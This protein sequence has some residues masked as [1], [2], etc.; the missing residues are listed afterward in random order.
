[1][2][3]IHTF[4]YIR[5]YVRTYVHAKYIHND[6]HNYI[7]TSTDSDTYT[8]YPRHGIGPYFK[9]A[10]NIEDALFKTHR[11]AVPECLVVLNRGVPCF[12]CRL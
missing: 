9:S 5:T 10:I 11:F 2:T 8:G 7:H 3:C 12:S 4:A 6:M 1:M